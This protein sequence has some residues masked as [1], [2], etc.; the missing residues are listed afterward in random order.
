VQRTVYLERIEFNAPKAKIAGNPPIKK[1]S[2]KRA[3]AGASIE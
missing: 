2:S 3:N 1:G